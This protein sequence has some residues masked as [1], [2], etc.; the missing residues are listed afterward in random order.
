LYR[1]LSNVIYPGRETVLTTAD[2]TKERVARFKRDGELKNDEAARSLMTHLTAVARYEEE[3]VADKVVKHVHG[4][5]RLLEHQ[6]ENG[7][8]TEKA[9]TVLK[10]DADS[11]IAKWDNR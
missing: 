7:W 9:Y 8:I 2:G 5:K 11:L 4:F 6:R 3:G 1:L 10:G